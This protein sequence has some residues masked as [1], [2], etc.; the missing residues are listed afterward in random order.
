DLDEP[1]EEALR[2]RRGRAPDLLPDLMGR[3]KPSLI[4]EVDPRPEEPFAF[5]R[6]DLGV[7]DP[8][9]NRL[10]AR[11]R[12]GSP[13]SPPAGSGPDGRACT[14]RA[15]GGA[16]PRDPGGGSRRPTDRAAGPPPAGARPRPPRAGAPAGRGGPR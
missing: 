5:L 13:A 3:E 15:G 8:R 11:A 9:Q 2:L 1:L 6:R 4:E 12:R 10:C 16:R 14:A 7:Q